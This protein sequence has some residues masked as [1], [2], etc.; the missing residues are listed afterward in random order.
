MEAF[1]ADVLLLPQWVQYWMDFLGIVIAVSAISFLFNKRLRMVGLYLIATT[2]IAVATMVWMHSQMGMVRLLGIVHVVFW[3][4]LIIYLWRKLQ[5]APEFSLYFKGII[6]VLMI[7]FTA[8]LIFDYYD[9]ARWIIG[10][11]APIV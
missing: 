3:T 8:A 11:R 6:W 7:T 1:E 9:V 10:Q 5:T 2:I 4:P